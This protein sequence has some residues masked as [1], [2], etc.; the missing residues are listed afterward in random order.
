MRKEFLRLALLSAALA[1]GAAT[2]RADI[3]VKTKTTVMGHASE[4]VTMIKGA[5]QRTEGGM[6]SKTVTVQQCDLRRNVQ[7]NDA[8]QTYLVMPFDDGAAEGPGAAPS[9]AGAGAP[10]AGGSVLYKVESIDTGERKE[11]F[12]MTARHVK[13]T[14]TAEA[15]PDSCAK[16]MKTVLDGWY[17]ELPG[18]N[19]AASAPPTQRGMP[20]NPGCRDQVRYK[21]SGT[22]KRGFALD[23]TMTMY[24]GEGR[25]TMEVRREVLELT[26]D[27]LDAALFE[28]PAGYREVAGMSE[29]YGG[30][31]GAGGALA[32]ALGRPTRPEP[33]AREGAPSSSSSSSAATSAAAP[34]GPKGSGWCCR[35]RRCARAASRTRRRP[36][37]S[38][39][40]SPRS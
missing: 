23:E 16:S 10:A 7:I 15:S 32:S 39:K 40:P 21:T 24:D 25:Q 12:G 14:I 11:M 22:G 37:R 5:R 30:G 18:F 31:G 29:L 17:V 20:S 1:C 4:G 6:G 34:P 36:R 33:S 35:A 28:V 26:R 2:A 19:C 13:T 9:S 8:A 27:T 38:A 3:R